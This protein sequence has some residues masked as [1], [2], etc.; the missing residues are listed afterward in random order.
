MRNPDRSR[1]DAGTSARKISI[2]GSL[3]PMLSIPD[4][5]FAA[6]DGERPRGRDGVQPPPAATAQRLPMELSRRL[7]LTMGRARG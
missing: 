2:R 1:A 3:G 6:S 5:S 7:A 4:T